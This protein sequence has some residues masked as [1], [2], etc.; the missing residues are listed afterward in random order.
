M[1]GIP[2]GTGTR[3]AAVGDWFER[4]VEANR[5]YEQERTLWP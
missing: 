3:G 1:A 4:A 5:R 2:T